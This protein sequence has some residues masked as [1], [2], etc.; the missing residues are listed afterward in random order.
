[1]TLLSHQAVVR[2]ENYGDKS[3]SVV[4]AEGRMMAVDPAVVQDVV[5]VVPGIM[6]SE[7]AD[8]NGTLVWSVTEG[9]RAVAR[10]I[11]TLGRSLKDLK[12]PDGIGDDHPG[13]GDEGDRACSKPARHPW[14]VESDHWLQ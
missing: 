13:D 4:L 8:R 3:R 1:M 14:H 5:V 6:G 11:R 12:L 7:L 9:R 2:T 10:A